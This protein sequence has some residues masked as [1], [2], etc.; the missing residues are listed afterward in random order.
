MSTDT[1]LQG[2]IYTF[3][4][5]NSRGDEVAIGKFENAYTVWILDFQHKAPLTEDWNAI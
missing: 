2:Y 4:T 1:Y 5:L 3:K